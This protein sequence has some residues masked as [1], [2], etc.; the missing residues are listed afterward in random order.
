MKRIVSMILT[1]ALVLG[2]CACG[3]S[4]EAA[5]QEQYD[6][7]VKYLSEGNYE[8]AIIAFTA[9]I[10]IDPKRPEAY[11]KAAE[12][13]EA[14][15]DFASAYNIL[16][17]GS[18]VTGS[19]ILAEKAETETQALISDQDLLELVNARTEED[20]WFLYGLSWG[21]EFQQDWDQK[22]E[23]TQGKIWF[24]VTDERVKKSEDIR[25]IWS[26]Y[27]AEEYYPVPDGVWKYYQDIDGRLYTA[28]EGIGGDMGY[29]GRVLTEVVSREGE[30]AILSGYELREDWNG[31]VSTQYRLPLT[32]KM[33]FTDG[34]WRC[35]GII[36][37]E[38]PVE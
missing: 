25:K 24:L 4:A 32:Y 23:D 8:E 3:Q 15:G 12:A 6:L 34:Q 28:N 18:D 19:Q 9:A 37:G 27:F 17:Q 26:E 33:A 21:A 22:I 20:F 35:A 11:L 38:E 7:G 16:L 2:L 5:W 30:V 1:I 36:V 31:S 14:M 13:Y 10:E 29:L